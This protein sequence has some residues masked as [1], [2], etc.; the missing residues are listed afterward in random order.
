[1]TKEKTFDQFNKGF[2]F[3]HYPFN[4]FTAESETEKQ[5]K[6]F[7]S[8][9]L[10]SPIVQAF[11]QGQ[12]MILSGDR[13]TGKT[14]II[15]DFIRNSEDNDLFCKIDD[16]SSLGKGYSESEFYRFLIT[17]IV[18]QF[19]SDASEGHYF[20]K[21]L[22]EEERILLAYF[23]Q[24]FA[25]DAT[26]GTASR[27]VRAIQTSP[28]KRFTQVAYNFVR[29]PLNIFANASVN[30]I[31]DVISKSAGTANITNQATEF[32]PEIKS[33]L[34]TEI[35]K[36][37]ATMEALRRLNRLIIKAG[38]RR[39]IVVMDKIDEDK[40]FDNA[41]EE[42]A[43]FIAP[44]LSDNKVL[45]DDTF[46]SVFSLWVVPLNFIKDKVRTQKIHSPILKWKHDDLKRAYDKRIEV[47]S[48][49][50]MATFDRVFADDVTDELKSHVLDLSNGNPRDLWHL[51]DKIFRRQ[52]SL[53]PNSQTLTCDACESGMVDFVEQFNFY[54]YY[55]RRANARA[56]SMDVYAYIR[57]LLKLDD[58]KFTRN[59]L[60]DRAGTGSSTLNY[61]VGMENLG[62]IEK[63]VTE[64]GANLYNIRD[65][66]VVFALKNQ[67]EIRKPQ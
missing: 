5:E 49:Q 32:F 57:H 42:I 62:L 36:A 60:S 14:S 37:E 64:K 16:F 59:Q 67:I 61:T 55:P 66:K 26:R 40:R 46:Q 53:D 7:V 45:L 43:D 35:P 6:L 9:K 48:S 52:Y 31:A 54:E 29:N 4:S 25:S 47:Y 2:G 1:M 38:Y 44:I 10:Y 21:S 19:F 17:A 20:K 58:P 8:T 34:E 41:A 65:P 39:I 12:T 63:D 33:G 24:N 22:S 51:F 15:F 23:Y 30:L 50:A 13:G 11:R 3:D 27:A 18:N 28:I 56:N